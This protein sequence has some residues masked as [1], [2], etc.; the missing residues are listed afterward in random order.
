MVRVLDEATLEAV[1]AADWY[2]RQ[3][4][5][6]GDRFLDEV[7]QAL[8]RIG[9]G[10]RRFPR[11]APYTGQHE[12]RRCLLRQ[13]PY[14]AIIWCRPAELVVIAIGHGRRRPLYWI[15]RLG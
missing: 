6:L 4:L 8:L 12:I 7:D 15:D 9:E 11:W 1:E 5:G 2:D 14:V 3:Q 10:P 13:F